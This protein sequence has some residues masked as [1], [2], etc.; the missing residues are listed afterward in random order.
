VT[1][2]W[3]ATQKANRRTAYLQVAAA[4]FAER[5]FGR[6]SID[7]LSAAAGVSGPA[8][9]NHFSGK[10]EILVELLVSASERLL[11]GGEQI[12]AEGGDDREVI[13]RLI[14]FH[15]D[16]AITERDII[17][18]QDRELAALP[19]PANRRVRSLQ[20]RYVDH[21]SEVLARI[22]PELDGEG[23][24]IRLLGTFGLLNSTPFSVRRS[25]A[26]AHAFSIRHR[27]VRCRW[28]DHGRVRGYLWSRG[29]SLADL[30]GSAGS[31][32]RRPE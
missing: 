2:T 26:S 12:M 28:T 32:Q 29:T 10:D 27:A 6:V 31:S 11:S 15:L 8:F 21:W 16:F 13:N 1:A 24:E 20:R 23:R 7:E 5:G 18:I 22:R 4:L 19:G 9:Y 17:R 3:R 25:R 14:T 30:V